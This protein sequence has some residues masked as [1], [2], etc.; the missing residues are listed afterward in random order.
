MATQQWK[1][2]AQTTTTPIGQTA[3]R[4]AMLP[5]ARTESILFIGSELYYNSFWLKMMFVAAASVGAKRLLRQADRKVLA[6]VDKGYTRFEKLAIESIASEGG[7]AIVPL[8]STQGLLALM[9]RERDE[10]KLRDVVFFCHGVPGKIELNFWGSPPVRWGL[11]NLTLV[12]DKAFAPDARVYSYACRSG[13][14]ADGESFA[15][16]TDALPD[17]S[18]ANKI[19]QWFGIE[20]HAFMRRTFYGDVLRDKSQSEKIASV[21]KK[22]RESEEGQRIDISDE[23]EAL[24][25]DGLGS[26][27]PLT[28]SFIR[29]RWPGSSSRE[30]TAAYAL[31]RKAGGRALPT[32]ASSPTGLPSAMRVFTRRA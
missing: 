20:V 18:L 3:R 12:S 4:E 17:E 5:V 23:Y 14:G 8:S 29:G 32:A 9:N 19:A 1:Q 16:E 27:E 22:L 10:F 30:G 31:W 13:V 25:H 24:P 28:D 15:S 21:L 2:R 26:W 7:F 11:N 6:Y